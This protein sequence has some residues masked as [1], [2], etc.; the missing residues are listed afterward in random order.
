[1]FWGMG[2]QEPMKRHCWVV[3]IEAAQW[4]EG[5]REQARVQA[6][7]LLPT[8]C[9]TLSKSLSISNLVLPST[10][11]QGGWTTSPRV[12]GWGFEGPS[13]PEIAFTFC[14]DAYFFWVQGPRSLSSIPP[15][16]P[17]HTPAFERILDPR[18][19]SQL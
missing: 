6:L 12:H 8:G 7:V 1:M 19:S 11:S 17:P 5:H 18:W 14:A 13:T 2:V 10:M 16:P 9:V 4:A 3:L 15:F